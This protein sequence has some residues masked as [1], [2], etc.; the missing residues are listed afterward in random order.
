MEEVESDASTGRWTREVV[1]G[2]LD[3]EDDSAPGVQHLPHPR[4]Y[5]APVADGRDQDLD[6]G[7]DD[8]IN[9]P[10]V[11]R[12]QGSQSNALIRSLIYTRRILP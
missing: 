8:A 6:A 11:S 9:D 12:A 3:V 2:A 5:V 7:F 4:V 1:E 10:V